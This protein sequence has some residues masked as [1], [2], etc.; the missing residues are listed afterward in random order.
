MTDW[1]RPA[2]SLELDR[3]DPFAGEWASVDLH[4]PMEWMPKGGEGFSHLKRLGAL[5]GYGFLMDFEAMTPFGGILGHASSS[6]T[7]S[8]AGTARSGTTTGP[9]ASS[10]RARSGP[11]AR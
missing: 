4:Q 2:R 8:A 6:T 10:A 1:S 9:T 5:D 3:L 7:A 11:T